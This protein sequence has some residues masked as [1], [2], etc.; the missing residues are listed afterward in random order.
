M[1]WSIALGFVVTNVLYSGG[2][3]QKQSKYDG[4]STKKYKNQSTNLL[5]VYQ[6][7]TEKYN[8]INLWSEFKNKK[9]LGVWI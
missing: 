9:V 8:L 1:K 3:M 2:H 4:N 5:I 7:Q 6:G